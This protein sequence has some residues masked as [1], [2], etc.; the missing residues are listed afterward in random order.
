MRPL[1][2]SKF[3]TLNT[4]KILIFFSLAAAARLQILKG[5]RPDVY[6]VHQIILRGHVYHHRVN[7]RSRSGDYINTKTRNYEAACNIVF[8]NRF[9]VLCFRIF[10][11]QL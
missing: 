2:N 1:W 3:E 8:N 10:P 6:Q 9:L 5:V 4:W 11:S 7:S